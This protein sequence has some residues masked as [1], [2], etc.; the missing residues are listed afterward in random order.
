M[1]ETVTIKKSKSKMNVTI[2]YLIFEKL[3]KWI[4]LKA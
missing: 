4:C 3:E 1:M 2:N